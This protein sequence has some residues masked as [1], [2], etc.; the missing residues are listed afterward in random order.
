[1]CCKVKQPAKYFETPAGG[2]KTKVRIKKMKAVWIIMMAAGLIGMIIC[3][4]K[5]K[6]M[7]IMQPVAFGLFIVVVIGAVMLLKGMLGGDS[8]IL[9]KEMAFAHSRGYM[10]GKF[11]KGKAAGKKVLFVADPSYAQSKTGGALLDGFKKAYGSENVVL[12]NVKVKASEESSIEEVMTAADM[13]ALFAAHE[14]AGVIITTIGLPKKAKNMK[15]FSKKGDKPVLFLLSSGIGGNNLGKY[16]KNGTISGGLVNNLKADY[17]AEAA[18]TPE[19][20]FKIRYVLVD[21]SNID[22]HMGMFE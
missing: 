19:D 13:D 11:L 7:P 6:T 10:V 5:Q 2:I 20:T 16:I 3:S 1:M 21:S 8:P 18:K 15:Y 14:D 9:N 4:K 17:R 22:K 12:D